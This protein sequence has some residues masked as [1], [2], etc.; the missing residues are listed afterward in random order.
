MTDREDLFKPTIVHNISVRI[1]GV[2]AFRHDARDRL[3]DIARTICDISET[4]M[5]PKSVE[6]NVAE[7]T[8]AVVGYDKKGDQ[9]TETPAYPTDFKVIEESGVRILELDR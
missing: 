7:E 8:L 6:L 1:V 2:E 9:V 3:K 4:M 5:K